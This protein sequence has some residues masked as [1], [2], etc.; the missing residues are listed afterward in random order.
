MLQE[1]RKFYW[2]KRDAIKK[3]IHKQKKMFNIIFFIGFC[4]VF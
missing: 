4:K 3:L 1:I 2:K